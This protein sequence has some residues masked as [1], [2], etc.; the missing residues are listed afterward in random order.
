MQFD[1]E[2]IAPLPPAANLGLQP[3]PLDEASFLT[4]NE[5]KRITNVPRAGLKRPR[6]VL[7]YIYLVVVTVF[8]LR[9]LKSINCHRVQINLNLYAF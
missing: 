4:L 7:V 8:L 6:H 5:R 3:Y 2:Y 1:Y 9:G